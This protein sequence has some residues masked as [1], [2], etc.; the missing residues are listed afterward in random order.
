[1]SDEL[2]ERGF[3]LLCWIALPA[4]P[5]AIYFAFRCTKVAHEVSPILVFLPAPLLAVLLHMFGM[6]FQALFRSTILGMRREAGKQED[7]ERHLARSWKILEII[8]LSCLGWWV[9]HSEPFFP[10]SLGGAGQ[11]SE[12]FPSGRRFVPRTLAAY[13]SVRLAYLLE[14]WIFQD[15][16][17]RPSLTMH[18]IATSILLCCA[19]LL[20][21][22]KFGSIIVFLH[23]VWNIPLQL[24]VWIQQVRCSSLYT[25]CLYLASLYFSFHLLFYSFVAEVILPSYS[26]E[27][28][29]QGEWQ[30]YWS[31]F[32]LLL[33]HHAHAVW[34]LLLYIPR[35]IK[36][37]NGAVA[38]ARETEGTHRD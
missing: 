37:P 15:G 8:C 31:M 3:R 7:L 35:F 32:A 12:M 28:A 1:M 9:V 4:Y 27:R 18:H 11:S 10:A 6:G 23:D 16:L 33:V 30:V 26:K 2:A 29:E 19:V 17:Q 38:R 24:L 34:R 14:W 21:W 25:I 20:G 36:S 22:V 13:H 5:I